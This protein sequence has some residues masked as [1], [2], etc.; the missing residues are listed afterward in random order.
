MMAIRSLGL[1]PSLLTRGL[2][3][4]NENPPLTASSSSP[5]SMRAVWS[6]SV[7]P[8]SILLIGDLLGFQN[9]SCSSPMRSDDDHI[10]HFILH[11]P[12]AGR[13][14]IFPVVQRDAAAREVQLVVAQYAGALDV[15]ALGHGLNLL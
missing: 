3:A 4:P 14:L 1:I 12:Q 15:L 9:T 11:I 8:V 13:R 10:R 6:F 7:L 5:D 2:L